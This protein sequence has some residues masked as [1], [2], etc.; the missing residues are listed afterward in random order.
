MN[1]SPENYPHYVYILYDPDSDSQQNEPNEMES[2][3][4]VGKG[5]GNRSNSHFHEL[6]RFLN[7]EDE[8]ESRELSEKLTKIKKIR[9][10]GREPQARIVGRYKTADEAFAVEAILIHWV[11]G[12][13]K[14]TNI[15]SGHGHEYVRRRE[16]YKPMDNLETRRVIGERDGAFTQDLRNKWEKFDID[17]RLKAIEIYLE[18]GDYKTQGFGLNGQ[19]P[20]FFLKIPG[21]EQLTVM[22][23][24]SLSEKSKVQVQLTPAEDTVEY[25][26]FLKDFVENLGFDPRNDTKAGPKFFIHPDYLRNRCNRNNLVEISN[27]IDRYV[28]LVEEYL[29]KCTS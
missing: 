4:Y 26:S 3:F 12:I 16:V 15:V 13:D 6:D 2:I 19:D 9:D 10:L 25:R 21:C 23:T 28:Q 7:S 22:I 5:K 20:S 11:Y 1:N 27:R 14:L 29:A 24:M 8:Q 18:N 17:E